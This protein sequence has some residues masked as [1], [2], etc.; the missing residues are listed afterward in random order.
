[1]NCVNLK[2]VG[3]GFS[4]LLREVVEAWRL[5]KGIPQF[6]YEVANEPVGIVRLVGIEEAHVLQKVP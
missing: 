4:P 2:Q 3:R 1:V 5:N 6:Q